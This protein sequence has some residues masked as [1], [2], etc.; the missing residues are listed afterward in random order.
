MLFMVE[1]DN[2]CRIII[3]G[4][5]NVLYHIPGRGDRHQSRCRPEIL[6]GGCQISSRWRLLIMTQ[7]VNKYEDNC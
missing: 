5:D 1:Y 6:G 7:I 4:V 3:V 2:S